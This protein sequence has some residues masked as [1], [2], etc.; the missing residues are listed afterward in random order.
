M[1]KNY[2]SKEI[3]DEEMRLLAI[4]AGGTLEEI[5]NDRQGI[6]GKFAKHA[7]ANDEFGGMLSIRTGVILQRLSE[8]TEEDDSAIK[9]IQPLN[10]FPADEIY[11][12]LKG[13]DDSASELYSLVLP[14]LKKAFRYG[15]Y[16]GM[17]DDK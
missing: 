7:C 3:D 15:Y 8:F 12:K 11:D 5:E 10:D 17:I 1:N 13:K 4:A 2:I 6:I 9:N 16:H 14:W